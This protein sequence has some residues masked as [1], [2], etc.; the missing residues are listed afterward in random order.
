MDAAQL[1]RAVALGEAVLA[2]EADLSALNR[3]SLELR[4]K[5]SRR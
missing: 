1:T 4:G 5:A 3:R 2:G